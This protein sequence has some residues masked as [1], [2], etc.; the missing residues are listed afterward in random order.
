MPNSIHSPVG[1]SA[2]GRKGGRKETRGEGREKKRMRPKKKGK[3]GPRGEEGRKEE[4]GRGEGRRRLLPPVVA[5][6]RR[7]VG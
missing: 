6:L 2:R 1:V 7:Y 5:V 3:N 4:D